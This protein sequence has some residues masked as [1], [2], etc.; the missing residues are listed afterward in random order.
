MHEVGIV[1]QAIEM[2]EEAAA[3]QNARRI[4][5]MKLRVGTLAGVVPEAMEF[6]FGIVSQGTLA[7]GAEFAWETVPVK[8]RC[9]NGCGDFCPGNAAVFACPTCGERSWDIIE[10]RELHLVEIDIDA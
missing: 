7:E 5:R 8:C 9:G 4:L 10:G 1:N 6:A 2:A 3:Q